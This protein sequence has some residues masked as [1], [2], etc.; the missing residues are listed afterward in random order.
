M[1]AFSCSE[2]P[3]YDGDAILNQDQPQDGDERVLH[4]EEANPLE[5]LDP[6]ELALRN[7][8]RGARGKIWRNID[9]DTPTWVESKAGE[10]PLSA[11]GVAMGAGLALGLVAR[12]LM[13]WKWL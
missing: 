1:D 8:V 2:H 7:V 6:L 13:P 9:P 4:P 10:R 12:R 3:L 11:A 5:A